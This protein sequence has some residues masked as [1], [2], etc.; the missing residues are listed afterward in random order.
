MRT[1]KLEELLECIYRKAEE[2]L[3]PTTTRND[4]ANGVHQN[5]HTAKYCTRVHTQVERLQV[6]AKNRSLLSGCVLS[7]HRGCEHHG[8]GAPLCH[9]LGAAPRGASP[10]RNHTTSQCGC[11]DGE[12]SSHCG[13]ALDTNL[14]I[15]ECSP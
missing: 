13:A 2:T 12:S 1:K 14:H 8:Q 3:I 5:H 11:R 10:K 6:Q 4:R 15:G 7:A 9:D